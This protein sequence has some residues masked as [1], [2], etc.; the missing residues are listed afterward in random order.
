[1]SSNRP[2]LAL[3]ALHR[4]LSPLCL[5]L[6]ALPGIA[7][8]VPASP[9]DPARLI[10]ANFGSDAPAPE[11]APDPAGSSGFPEGAGSIAE[12]MNPDGKDN[13][14]RRWAVFGQTT[15]TA[16]TTTGFRHPYA[17]DHSLPVNDL[18]ETWDAS[19]YLGVRPWRGGEIWATGEVDQGFGVGNT[20]GLAGYASGEAYKLGAAHPYTR[21]QRL[22]LR[23]TFALG[24]EQSKL[25]AAANQMP[26]T[27][28]A[29]R[30]VITV[31]KFGVADV[32]DTNRYAHDPRS[33]FLNWSLI[34]AGAF[35]YAGDPWG[36]SYGA[37]GELVLGPWTIRTGLFDMTGTPGGMAP[38]TDFSFYQVVG[39]VEHRHA[40]DG[41]AGA[42]RGALWM[43][44]GR[45][46]RYADAIAWGTASASVPDVAQVQSASHTRIGGYI[47]AEQE[48]TGNLGAFV[49]L[50]AADGRY[51]VFD[52]TDIDRS[53]SA[54][55]S[56]AGKGWGRAA[57]TLALGM[58]A[59]AA[60][61]QARAYFAAG[62]LGLLI[63]DGA[64]PH[65]GTE[66]IAE[67]SY[68]WRPITAIAVTFDAQAIANPAYNRDRGPVGVLGL[69]IHAAF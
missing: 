2:I 10:L 40:I 44:H 58:V 16:M 67:A 57:D 5:G 9:A 38:V 20:L 11:P 18:R 24:G 64:L 65:A 50:S 46:G 23:Q 7:S 43:N 1:M 3:P 14:P 62:G 12:S 55:L 28:T 54:G 4:M 56:L 29:N 15:F 13:S 53:V 37:A 41:H 31:G 17:G 19:L 8:A 21:L 59:N 6:I 66:M 42:I 22:Y 30:L 34:D 68:S 63:G 52:F 48:L 69:R 26:G 33:D 45:L 25:D 35:D 60:S 51:A 36:F 39:E 47:N 61:R 27:Q 32:F 49:R